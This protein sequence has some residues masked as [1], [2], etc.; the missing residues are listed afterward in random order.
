MGRILVM[1]GL[2]ALSATMTG[3]VWAAQRLVAKPCTTFAPSVAA[4]LHSV[5]EMPLAFGR[6]VAVDAAR[7]QVTIS[8]RGLGAFYVEAGTTRFEIRDT[9]QL[10]G[11]SLGDKV[12]FGVERD[13]KRLAVTR[14]EHSN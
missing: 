9:S 5:E 13:G 4:S 14:L 8:H 11:L 1:A 2:A 7:G 3:G 10:L 6:I 12:R